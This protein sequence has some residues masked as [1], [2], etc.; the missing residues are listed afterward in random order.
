V[1]VNGKAQAVFATVLK[2]SRQEVVIVIPEPIPQQVRG[3]HGM[4][5][6]IGEEVNWPVL[7]AYQA[8]E[9]VDE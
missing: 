3:Q 5:G 4:D 8:G 9:Q 7:Q 6:F 1:N 2:E